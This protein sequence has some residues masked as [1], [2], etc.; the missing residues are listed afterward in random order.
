MSTNWRRGLEDWKV[1]CRKQ[2]GRGCKT[3][4]SAF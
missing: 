3:L 2:P 4:L 1:C